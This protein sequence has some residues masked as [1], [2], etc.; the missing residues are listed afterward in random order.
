MKI[1]R[2]ETFQFLIHAC[3]SCIKHCR[4]GFISHHRT[5]NKLSCSQFLHSN[6][7]QFEVIECGNLQSFSF[8]NND[9]EV[10][11]NLSFV[12]RRNIKRVSYLYIKT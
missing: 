4:Y 12:N 3:A 8:D 11:S 2:Q 1:V 7:K 6:T 10:L 9:S 5:K